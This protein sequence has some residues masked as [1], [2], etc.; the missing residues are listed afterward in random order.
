M[1]TDQQVE[2]GTKLLLRASLVFLGLAF[3]Y[4]IRDI[5]ILTFLAIV[6]SSSLSP[7][8][9]WFHYKKFPRA[10]A[11]VF[12][13]V[14]VLVLIGLLITLIIPPFINQIGD[15][16][17][18]I[19]S[20]V[21]KVSQM[22]WYVDTHYF[23]FDQKAFLNNVEGG[24][25]G[26]FSGFFST[27]L[28]FF[29]G[30]ISFIV[31]FFLSLYMSLEENGVEKFLVSVTPRQYKEYVRTIATRTQRKISHWLLGQLV[32]MLTVFAMYFI[33]LSLLG[34]PYALLLATLGGAFEIIPY[35]GPIIAAIPAILMATLVSP[36]LGLST[37]IFYTVAHQIESHVITPQ[38]MK[39]AVGVNPV[40]II[41]SILIGAKLGGL[42]GIILAVPAAA[43][44]GIFVEDFLER[45]KN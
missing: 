1:T 40:A 44:I 42:L 24:V 28:G 33:G 25:T 5:I 15:F 18:S 30:L 8:I 2:V 9:R 35:I 4:M 34:V 32:L 22:L 12:V 16:V 37:L 23:N 39:R 27:T 20:Y 45:R 3:L 26:S 19:P 43:V 7:L 10:S 31:F 14:S 13:Y 11:V 21:D 17:D 6:V 41:L 29:S 36:I 38:V